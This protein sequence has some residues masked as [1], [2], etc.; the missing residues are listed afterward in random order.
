MEEDLKIAPITKVF[1]IIDS[2]INMNQL[3]TCIKIAD[4]YTD[5][6]KRKGVINFNDVKTNIFIKILEKEQELDLAENFN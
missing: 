2:C 4:M 5:I 6:A 3:K 1:S